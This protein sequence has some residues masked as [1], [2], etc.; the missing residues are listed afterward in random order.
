MG[1]VGS[2]SA[3]LSSFAVIHF[4]SLKQNADPIRS[5]EFSLLNVSSVFS[6]IV[7]I[8]GAFLPT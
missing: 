3:S 8:L 1:V 5:D 2:G 7:L 4:R 6:G